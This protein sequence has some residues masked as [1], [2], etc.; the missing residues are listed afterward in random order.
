ME[1]GNPLTFSFA[2][3]PYNY[4]PTWAG[5]RRPDLVGHPK[6]RD[7][8]RDMG[9]R[10]NQ[11]N[12]NPVYDINDFA[13][14]AAFTTGNAG[15]NIVDGTP[16]V[17][18]QASAKKNVRLTERLNFEI[19]YDYKNVLKIFSFLPPT[20]TVD[21]QNPKTFAKITSDPNTSWWGGQP[22]MNIGLALTW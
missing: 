8:W 11:Q 16:I 15:R 17:F 19:R 5:S 14:P 13:Y 3:S 20:T 10:F 4:F 22:L 12:I 9:D 21:F 18:A 6:L 2:N 7:N 1:G